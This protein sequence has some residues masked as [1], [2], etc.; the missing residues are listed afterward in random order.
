MAL[1]ISEHTSNLP[2]R[3]EV[4]SSNEPRVLV[5]PPD[6]EPIVVHHKGIDTAMKKKSKTKP[7]IVLIWTPDIIHAGTPEPLPPKAVGTPRGKGVRFRGMQ[8]ARDE[9]P[10]HPGMRNQ[11]W[12]RS[13]SVL[14]WNM[15]AIILEQSLPHVFDTA[16]RIAPTYFCYRKLD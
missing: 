10:D 3:L 2:R 14:P 13:R 4:E 5:C 16:S 11:E 15:H 1:D 6:F 8:V 9:R 12:A 7:F